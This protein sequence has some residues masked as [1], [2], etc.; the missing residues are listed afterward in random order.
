MLNT[1][2]WSHVPRRIVVRLIV[3]AVILCVA[4]VCVVAFIRWIPE[5]LVPSKSQ[6]RGRVDEV[7][8][9]RTAFLTMVAGIIAVAGAVYTGK[10]YRLSRQGQI[11]DR[12]TRAIDQLGNDHVD[13]RLGSIYAL[14]RLARES[15]ADQ[16]QII[17][18]LTGYI[19]QHAPWLPPANSTEIEAEAAPAII[20]PPAD[21]HAALRAIGRRNT[22]NDHETMIVN[23]S[24]TDLRSVPFDHGDFTRAYFVKARLDCADLSRAELAGADFSHACLDHADLTGARLEGANFAEAR[25]RHTALRFAQL[26][27]A[28]LRDADL[29]DANLFGAT[30]DQ[31]DLWK[32]KL[33]DASLWNTRLARVA[34]FTGVDFS[35]A[36]DND[37]TTWPESRSLLK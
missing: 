36:R 26:S 3:A 16:G 13:I 17:E 7:S 33:V 29:S 20:R 4:A 32:A 15:S 2:P 8:K 24:G 12:L 11:T 5:A 25:L 21:I 30:L 37:E 14:E 22:H 31:V 23:L 35:G 34:D 1:L 27:R 9:V 28:T 19:R 10:T 6:P 18:I